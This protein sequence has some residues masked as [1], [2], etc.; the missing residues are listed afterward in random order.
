MS[1]WCLKLQDILHC[2]EQ[3]FFAHCFTIADPILLPLGYLDG[4]ERH[5]SPLFFLNSSSCFQHQ[6]T[7]NKVIEKEIDAE[8]PSDDYFEPVAPEFQGK[9]AIR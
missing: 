8:H 1:L 9:E 3:G 5:Y 7:D 2:C 4:D 6:G